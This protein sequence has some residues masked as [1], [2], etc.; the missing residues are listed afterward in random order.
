MG[1]RL[2]VDL[3]NVCAQFQEHWAAK[4]AEWF[5][6]TVERLDAWDAF[7]DETHFENSR[8]FWAW[9][10]NVPNFWE[11]MPAVPGAFGAIL[12]L[13]R[14][15]NEIVFITSRDAKF[16]A[17]TE[18]WLKRF[19]PLQLRRPQIHHTMESQKGGISVQ[20]YIDD[21]PAVLDALRGKPCVLIFDRPW[22][23]EVQTGRGLH[24]VKGWAGVRSFISAMSEG[25]TPEEAMSELVRE[26]EELGLY[27]EPGLTEEEIAL[28][29]RD[30][31]DEAVEVE[32]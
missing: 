16:R 24:R 10:E 14:Q 27:E 26:T 15:G 13:A 22:N 30:G 5:G 8:E 11:S 7:V 12:D 29:T 9:V 19:W 32:A 1:Y 31:K 17:A 23:R 20:V 28:L 3:D 25:L 4:Y 6:V 21:S 18:T 2:G